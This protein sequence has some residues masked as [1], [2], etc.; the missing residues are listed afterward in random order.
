MYIFM[1]ILRKKR[2]GYE[3]AVKSE[4]KTRREFKFS[5]VSKLRQIKPL[6]IRFLDSIKQ[7]Q[8]CHHIPKKYTCKLSFYNLTMYLTKREKTK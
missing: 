8:P 7:F 3:T 1:L 4:K 5:V 6:R 2:K